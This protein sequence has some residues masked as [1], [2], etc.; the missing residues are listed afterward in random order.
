MLV[1]CNHLAALDVSLLTCT[2]EIYLFIHVCEYF[3][4]SN[5][6]FLVCYF[7]YISFV[8]AFNSQCELSC[9]D[10][11]EDPKGWL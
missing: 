8:W 10:M 2:L 6:G 11:G 3:G 9:V 1:G 4:N 5:V 7:I